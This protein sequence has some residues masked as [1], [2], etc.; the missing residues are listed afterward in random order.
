MKR[1][2]SREV[3]LLS[4]ELKKMPYKHLKAAGWK[5]VTGARE[6]YPTA[7]T[8]SQLLRCLEAVWSSVP[9]VRHP[10]V[11]EGKNYHCHVDRRQSRG[12]KGSR[13]CLRFICGEARMQVEYLPECA[14]P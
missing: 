1:D 3:V 4:N 2:L 7:A 10:L 9:P 13:I 12:S 5:G 14:G 6:P 8:C 11:W